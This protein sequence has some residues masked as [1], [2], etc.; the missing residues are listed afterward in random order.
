MSKIILNI[1]LF[2]S[3]SVII[4]CSKNPVT[5]KKDFM[6]MSEKREIALGQQS[7]P[8]IIQAYGIYKDD[9]M[10]KFIEQKGQQMAKISHRAGLKYEFKVVDSPVV[11]AFAVPGGFVYFTRGIMAHFN[12]EAEFAGVL[13]HEIGHIAARHSAKQYSKS[14]VAQIGMIAGMIF[15]SEF[16]QYSEMA[17]QGVGLLFL[18]FGR[19][20]ES[21][22]DKLGVS[23]S[24]SIGYDA[25]EMGGFFKTIKRLRDQS[26]A[27]IPTFL[28]THPDPVDRFNKVNELAD[29]QQAMAGGNRTYRI[30]RDPYLRMIDGLIYGEDPKQ[31]FVENNNFYHPELKFYFKVPSG[32]DSHNSPSQ[33]QMVDKGQ[34]AMMLLTL[35]SKKNLNEAMQEVAQKFQIQIV[36]N[37]SIK[38]NGNPAMEV[39]GQSEQINSQIY[40]IQYQG[41]IYVLTG[42]AKQEDFQRF[43]PIFTTTMQSFNRLTDPDK[44][45]RQP[46]VIKIVSAPSTGN[47]KT[48]MTQLKVPSSRLEELSVLNGMEVGE[49]VKKGTLLKTIAKRK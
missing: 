29:K 36:S 33:F 25:H 27:D 7:D 9:K 34:K 5:G 30:N 48:V 32:W 45:N 49:Q 8:G 38:V 11:N 10:Q 23:Y 1:C 21:Q 6:L 14:I 16:R 46:D 40:L 24:T 44:L 42:V 31:G 41:L 39:M 12:N 26:G 22:S 35:S 2:L 13:G 47:F 4:Q 18:K 3:L 15:S 20:A 17:Q 37:R 19:D 43:R 28:S